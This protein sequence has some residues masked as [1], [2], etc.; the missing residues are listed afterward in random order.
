MAVWTKFNAFVAD[1]ANGVHD[2]GADALQVALTN[3][4]P[5]AT[6]VVIA[7]IAQISAA[8]GYA[9]A[10]V[11]VN[12]SDQAGGVY[13]LGVDAITWNATGA[14]YDAFRYLVLYNS[15]IGDGPLIAFI[16]YGTSYVL[17]DTQA[18]THQAGTLLTIA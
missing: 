17:P 16:D 3:T 13:S 5:N 14:P 15:S 4:A 8:G 11:T 18:F 6:N 9:P 7:D 12:S 10:A 1:L 2:L